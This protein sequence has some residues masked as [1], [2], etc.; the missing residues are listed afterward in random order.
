MTE[1]DFRYKMGLVGAARDEVGQAAALSWSAGRH[2]RR[3]LR[4][5]AGD[6]REVL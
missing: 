4:R 2:L 6:R 5:L 1:A 3:L